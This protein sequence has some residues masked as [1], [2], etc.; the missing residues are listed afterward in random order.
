MIIHSVSV[1]FSSCIFYLNLNVIALEEQHNTSEEQDNVFSERNGSFSSQGSFD[2]DCSNKSKPRRTSIYEQKH[3]KAPVIPRGNIISSRT[4]NLFK[5]YERDMTSH[6]A[7]PMINI[8]EDNIDISQIN[9]DEGQ[10]DIDKIRAEKEK[11]L[12][13]I[14]KQ[15]NQRIVDEE[16][17]RTAARKIKVGELKSQLKKSVLLLHSLKHLFFFTSFSSYFTASTTEEWIF[18]FVLRFVDAFALSHYVKGHTL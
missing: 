10:S 13:E 16:R 18:I 11:E 7:R 2:S 12:L 14:R 1:F 15:Y 4:E 8:N 9:T 5:N 17:E 6:E 3:I